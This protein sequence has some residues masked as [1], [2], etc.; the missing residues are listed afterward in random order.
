[1]LAV[2]RCIIQRDL[3]LALRR[4]SDVATALLFFVTPAKG[5]LINPGNYSSAAV[6]SLYATSAT[7]VGAKR[8]AAL[9]KLQ[10]T[11]ANDLPVVPIAERPSIIVVRKGITNWFGRS[12]N[13]INFWYLKQA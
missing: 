2:A 3:L 11:L 7:T 5:G 4:R 1:M 6:D 12:D 10:D 8:L 9:H 13:T